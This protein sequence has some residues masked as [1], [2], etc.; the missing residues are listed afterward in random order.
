MIVAKNLRNLWLEVMV[1]KHDY[2]CI[3]YVSY[4]SVMLFISTVIFQALELLCF[5]SH[6]Q[7]FY[8]LQFMSPLCSVA[9]TRRRK[10][11]ASLRRSMPVSH[12]LQLRFCMLVTIYYNIVFY[13]FISSLCMCELLIFLLSHCMSPVLLFRILCLL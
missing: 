12:L 9:P 10:W 2:K 11:L 3:S 5:S 8:Q 4:L 13:V 1:R 7:Y 6:L